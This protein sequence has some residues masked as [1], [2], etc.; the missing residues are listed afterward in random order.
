MIQEYEMRKGP[1]WAFG[2]EKPPLPL[3]EQKHEKDKLIT[4]F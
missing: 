3:I 2:I 4:M 1:P